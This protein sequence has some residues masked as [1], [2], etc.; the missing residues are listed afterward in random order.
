V[1]EKM[2][3]DPSVMSLVGEDAELWAELGHVI[4]AGSGRESKSQGSSRKRDRSSKTDGN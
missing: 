3:T 2:L 4:S 1:V